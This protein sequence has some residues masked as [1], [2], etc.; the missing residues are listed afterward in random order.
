MRG[1]IIAR[2]QVITAITNDRLRFDSS[3]TGYISAFAYGG[4]AKGVYE[5]GLKYPL[6]NA[7]I[8]DDVPLGVSNFFSGGQ[9]SVSVADGTLIIMWN[10]NE[11]AELDA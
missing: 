8:H 7:T 3:C 6:E 4:D 1:Y 5:K 11:K 9:S 2:E 10:R